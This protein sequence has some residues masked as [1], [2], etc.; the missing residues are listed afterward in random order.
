MCNKLTKTIFREIETRKCWHL[1]SELEEL[2]IL[3]RG[4]RIET[5]DRAEFEEKF[6]GGGVV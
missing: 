2:I 1:E 6:E 5:F 3:K 4:C